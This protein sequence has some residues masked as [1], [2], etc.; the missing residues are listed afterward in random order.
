M[1]TVDLGKLK[2]T[3]RR[4][5]DY[6]LALQHPDGYWWATLESNVTMTAELLLLYTI[7]GITERLPLDKIKTYILNQQRQHGGWELYY[8]DGGDLN[9]TIEAY[10]ALRLLGCR[11]DEPALQKAKNLILL[12]GGVTRA[13]IFTKL[14][15]ALIGCYDWR[16]LPSL[17]PWLMLLPGGGLFSI[18]EMSSW[19][20]S[21]TVPLIMVFDKKPVYTQGFN[22]DELYVK[23]PGERLYKL[24]Q[25]G[26]WTDVFI[27]LD[28]GFKLAEIWQVTPFRNEGLIAAEKWLL[29]R[30][31]ETGDWGGIQPAMVNSLL[32]LRCLDYALDEPAVVR[33]LR[34]VEKFCVETETE[35]WMQP[36]VSPVWDTALVVR[37]LVDSG[38]APDHPALVRAGEWLL[39]QQI[40]NT[41]G[42]WAVK[43]PQARPG[44]WAF[45]FD[46]RYYPDVDDTAV[47]VMAL[48]QIRLPNE[49]EKH[50]A[51][52]RA[53]DWIV[54]MQCRDGSWGAFDKD[55]DQEWL[56]FL[57]YGDLRAMIDPGTADVTARVLEMAHY[58]GVTLPGEVQQ[59][60]MDYLLQAQEATGSWFGRWGVNY[61]YGTSGVL[62][63]LR[64]E[65]SA[66]LAQQRGKTW[67]LAHQNPD[68]GWGETCRSYQDPSLQGQG[69]STVSQTAWGVLGLLAGGAG[70]SPELERGIDYLLAQQK[71]DGSWSETL[72]TGTGFPQHFYLR[73]NLYY[74][75]FPLMALGRYCQQVAMPLE[76]PLVTQGLPEPVVLEANLGR[77]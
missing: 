38:L 1:T 72:F 70:E 23:S 21:S 64:G 57:P 3:I 26:D 13:R 51:I 48:A 27:W 15:L 35:Y 20:R 14:N 44:G 65:A 4:S 60:G 56:N 62:A 33:G 58:P 59:R 49:G 52:Q 68:G 73:Y 71:S 43:N 32:A 69:A 75:H 24:P 16:G 7:W 28:Q 22:L 31:E 37:A 34:A 42:D 46:N 11:P 29:Q 67:L 2:Q 40:L 19:A 61:I 39:Q 45:E 50:Q 9:C 55:N 5:Q 25:K 30:Q 12:R 63:A 10:M 53:V 18:Y 8:D 36:C 47:V 54:S 77:E 74:Q 6:L 41:Y 17:P 76:I 66:E